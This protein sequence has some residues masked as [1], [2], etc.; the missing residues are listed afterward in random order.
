MATWEDLNGLSD[1]DTEEEANLA[2]MAS[3]DSDLEP[4]SDFEET[5]EQIK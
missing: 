5:E 1:D 3:V 2:L 4:E